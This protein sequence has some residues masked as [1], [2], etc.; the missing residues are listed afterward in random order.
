VQFDH[1]AQFGCCSHT[2]CARGRSQKYWG[3]LGSRP[4][5]WDGGRG[6]SPRETRYGPHVCYYTEFCRSWSNRLGIIMEI[7]QNILT[8]RVPP[9]KVT[10]GHW[11][12]HWLIGFLIDR[13]LMTSCYCSIITM[14]LSRTVYDID[15]D[16]GR[17]SQIFPTTRVF[18]A[19]AEGV[20]TGSF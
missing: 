11:N 9:F 1:Q 10:Q 8:P 2:L 12:R 14:A 3:T 16:F 19:P 15:G 7:R 6:H 5:P 13:L 18:N 17:K 4:S 20:P